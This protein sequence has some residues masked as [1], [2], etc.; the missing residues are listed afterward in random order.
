MSNKKKS[1]LPKP[2]ILTKKQAKEFERQRTLP[3]REPTEAERELI[4]VFFA[5]T[6]RVD[7]KKT[8]HF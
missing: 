5:T 6:T 1:D 8:T 2:H 3:P 4:R 7:A